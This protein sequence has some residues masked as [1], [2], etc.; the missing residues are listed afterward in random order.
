[1]VNSKYDSAVHSSD[2]SHYEP[3]D[4]GFFVDRTWA[5][6]WPN[7]I[8]R[9]W[10]YQHNNHQNAKEIE[11]GKFIDFPTPDDR[12]YMDLLS[13]DPYKTLQALTAEGFVYL[14]DENAAEE[15]WEKWVFTKIIVKTR[16]QATKFTVRSKTTAVSLNGCKGYKRKNIWEEQVE[17]TGHF[18]ILTL[19]PKPSKT[20][21]FAVALSDYKASNKIYPLC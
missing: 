7:V 8:G 3:Q 14:A 2:N 12:W 11:A 4:I 6:C 19:P 20:S 18:V 9:A 10:H 5:L 16:N 21:D 13:K 15:H 17:G 1:M